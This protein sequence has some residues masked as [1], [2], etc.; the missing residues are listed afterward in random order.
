[1]SAFF[2]NIFRSLKEL[3]VPRKA[4]PEEV[5]AQ[6]L[7]SVRKKLPE[8]NVLISRAR[9]EMVM[10]SQ[11][12]RHYKQ[13]I[14]S[15]KKQLSLAPSEAAAFEIQARIRDLEHRLKSKEELLENSKE[16]YNKM[17]RIKST[18]ESNLRE[19]HKGFR[20]A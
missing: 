13:E 1:M 11:N 4:S 8:M 6:S 15:V 18:F 12:I 7:E 14:S 17:I 2:S 10:F 3:L 20:P 19:D 9:N 5:L 16:N